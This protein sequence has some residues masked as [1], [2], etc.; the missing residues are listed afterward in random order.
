[1]NTALALALSVTVSRTVKLP[2]A[3]SEPVTLPLLVI[4]SPVGRPVTVH[5]F[6]PL[7]PP[8]EVTAIDGL[9]PTLSVR[10]PVGAVTCSAVDVVTVHTKVTEALCPFASVTVTVGRNR[11][12]ADGVPEISPLLLMASP[13]GRFVADQVYGATPPVAAA[14]TP[15]IAEPSAELRAVV[16]G[17]VTLGRAA[18]VQV[19]LPVVAAA[20]V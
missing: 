19:K 8:L 2:R 1:M 6:A 5:V 3:V 17:T 11:V 4:D 18:T 10:S 12:P 7:A 13:V 20:P 15:P 9:T 16:V 14:C